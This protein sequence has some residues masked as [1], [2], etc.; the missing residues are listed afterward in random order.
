MQQCRGNSASLGCC[1]VPCVY[2]VLPS[3]LGAE[4]EIKIGPTTGRRLPLALPS[5][6]TS[7]APSLRV[8]TPSP[9]STL[10][11]SE[12]FFPLLRVAS[13]LTAS[14]QV[15]ATWRY[16]RL[17]I[18][19]GVY[20]YAVRSC[21]AIMLAV[22]LPVTELTLKALCCPDGPPIGIIIAWPALRHLHESYRG[23]RADVCKNMRSFT[24]TRRWHE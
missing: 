3:I 15:M 6:A 12:H 18:R 10:T 22:S 2:S 20:P 21:D 24:C 16:Y 19:D 13:F 17:K 9:S 4:V 5:L 23:R 8:T 7:L 11:I 14:K 1:S